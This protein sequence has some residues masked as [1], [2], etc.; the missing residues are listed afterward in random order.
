M[1]FLLVFMA[2]GF[3][4]LSGCATHSYEIKGDTVYLYF[5][6]SKAKSVAL[7]SSLDNYQLHPAR[8]VSSD[9]WEVALRAERDFSYF[10]VV[11]RDSIVTPCRL[12]EKDD[13]GGSNC[14]FKFPDQ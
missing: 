11:D 1:K 3:W 2:T 10:Y 12:Q 14:I 6:D 7:A 8:R 13:F 9:M 4:A 5:R